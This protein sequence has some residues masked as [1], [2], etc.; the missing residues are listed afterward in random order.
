MKQIS[1]TL[2]DNIVELKQCLID[3]DKLQ[4]G[5]VPVKNFVTLLKRFGVKAGP[6]MIKKF[7]KDG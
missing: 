7:E 5:V 4:S 3:Q 1:Q 2:I 6:N